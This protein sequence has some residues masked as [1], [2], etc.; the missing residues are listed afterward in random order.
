MTGLFESDTISD[1]VRPSRWR[2]LVRAL[3]GRPADV[4]AARSK[5]LAEVCT[6]LDTAREIVEQG[7]T[8]GA[9]FVDDGPTVRACLVGAVVRASDEAKGDAAGPTIDVLWD[10]WQETRGHGGPGLAGPVP[11][12]PVR[13]A[14]VRDLTRWNDQ[15]GRTRDEVLHLVDLAS[16][17]AIMTAMALPAKAPPLDQLR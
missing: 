2:R 12:P 10:A 13:L 15:P 8:Q 16:S 6:V 4:G 11:A 5:R 3:R 9:W 1:P 14:R 17:R 7:W